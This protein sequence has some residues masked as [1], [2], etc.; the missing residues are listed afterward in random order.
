VVFVDPKGLRHHKPDDPKVR[1]HE[2]IKDIEADLR[3]Q[4]PEN[5]GIELHAFLISETHSSQLVSQWRDVAGQAVTR[6]LMESWNILFRDEDDRY[7]KK[8][9]ERVSGS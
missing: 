6:E 5:A 8:L 2:T 1:F 7:V 3:K 9:I 4:R